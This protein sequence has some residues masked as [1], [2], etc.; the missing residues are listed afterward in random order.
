M[1]ALRNPAP[2]R[3]TLDEFLAWAAPGDGTG[4]GWQ[5]IDG[6]P[7]AAVAEGGFTA[8]AAELAPAEAEPEAG[9]GAGVAPFEASAGAD[10]SGR[11]SVELDCGW[12][13]AFDSS[14]AA[15]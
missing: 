10:R 8:W 7:V 12:P 13:E 1:V 9:A 6:E 15:E 5:L 11:P 4:R 3:M 2:A 14:V